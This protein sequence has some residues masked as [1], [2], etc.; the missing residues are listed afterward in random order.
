M[1]DGG[2]EG[3]GLGGHKGD[4]KL[5]EFVV[6]SLREKDNRERSALSRIMYSDE[7]R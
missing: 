4:E 3:G 7:L 2:G 6:S 1:G 5:H